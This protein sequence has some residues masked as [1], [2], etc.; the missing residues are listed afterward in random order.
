MII[1]I[2]GLAGAGTST[3]SESLAD[4]LGMEV[5]S[6]GEVFRREAEEHGMSLEEFGEYASEN[7]EVDRRIDERQAE[8][9]EESEELIVEGRLAGWMVEEPDLS[10][11]LK[12]PREVRVG[13]VSGREGESREETLR[14]V[15][16]REEC[17]A[18][19]YSELY[20]IDISDMEVY[21]LVVDTSTWGPEGVKEVVLEGIEALDRR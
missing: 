21:D 17:E 4:E 12:A 2:S 8:I 15:E 19:R 16:S 14:K 7:P 3:T 5:L 13:R 11:W 1:T 10:V 18:E 9:A 6:A 20:G